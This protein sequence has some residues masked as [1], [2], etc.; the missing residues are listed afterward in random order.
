MYCHF[1]ILVLA[2]SFLIESSFLDTR[3]GTLS[4][5]KLKS[6]AV[7]SYK[8]AYPLPRP[9]TYPS[10]AGS[11][12]KVFFFLLTIACWTPDIF[13]K[14]MKNSGDKRVIRNQNT[15]D[16]VIGK[17]LRWVDPYLNSQLVPRLL[18]PLPQNNLPS[19]DE[20]PIYLKTSFDYSKLLEQ[21]K[22]LVFHVYI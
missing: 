12:I 17:L 21:Q 2:W 4:N 13:P 16:V 3:A 20:N 19:V 5:F 9:G 7:E 18:I 14:L 15:D 11:P 22:S 10:G 6:M 8:T 1:S